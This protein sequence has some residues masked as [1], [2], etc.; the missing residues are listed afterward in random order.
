MP[1][2]GQWTN[3]LDYNGTLGGTSLTNL[4]MDPRTMQIRG[5]LGS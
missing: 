1:N 2:L 4:K 3:N 5:L